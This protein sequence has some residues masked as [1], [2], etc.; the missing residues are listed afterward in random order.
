MEYY[1]YLLA[2]SYFWVVT[3]L[4]VLL[5]FLG[6]IH[7]DFI[8]SEKNRKYERIENGTYHLITRQKLIHLILYLIS[9]FIYFKI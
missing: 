2:K 7:P 9:I 5:F 8:K 1:I 4:S 6:L 3:A